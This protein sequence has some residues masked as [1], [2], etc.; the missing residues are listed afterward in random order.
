MA[1]SKSILA[2]AALVAL[3]AGVAY[4]QPTFTSE[5]AAAGFKKYVDQ[6]DSCHG[7]RLDGGVGGGPPLQGDYFFN[8]WGDQPISSVFEYIKTAMPADT[9]N[10]LS[11]SSVAQILAYIL[12]FN[13]LEPGDVPL[14]TTL[15]ELDEIILEHP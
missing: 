13:G 1:H 14:P 3:T 11:S 9:P 8:L 6:C 15:L 5:Q 2:A 10:S 4:A 12:A 7:D